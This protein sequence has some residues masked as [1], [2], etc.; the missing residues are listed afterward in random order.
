MRT[1]TVLVVILIGGCATEWTHPTANEEKFFY[2]K[3]ECEAYAGIQRTTVP[4]YKTTPTYDTNCRTI[5]N[6]V[7][8]TTTQNTNADSFARANQAMA[9][10]GADLAL[11]FTRIS[12]FNECMQSKNYRKK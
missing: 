1:I 2:D 11:A 9:Q 10:G 6:S 12:R 7:N 4:E 8:C 3:V 5:G